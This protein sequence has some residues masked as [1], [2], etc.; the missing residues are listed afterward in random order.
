MK[1]SNE[2]IIPKCEGRAFELMKGQILRVIALEG[3]QVG[4]MVTLNLRDFRETF[5]SH[6][7][8][9]L[10]GSSFRKATRLYSGPPFFKV[11]LVIVDDKVG[12]H[13][14]HGRCTRGRYKVL[15]GVDNHANC[16]DNIVEALRPYGPT[17]Y[18]VP[19]DTFNIFMVGDID[20]NNHYTF[21][22]PLA[23]KGEYIDFRAEM[24]LLVAI[25]ACPDDS[26]INDYA[27][28]PL[29]VEI[30]QGEENAS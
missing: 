28:K 17:E 1:L 15:Y 23:G 18:D 22:P 11:M 29:K 12:V 20:E 6:T 8:C 25:S 21:R 3:K 4:D 26:E 5:S 10:N 7:T 16:H 14:I 30:R 24:D 27:P 13:W 9:S 19:L 2:F